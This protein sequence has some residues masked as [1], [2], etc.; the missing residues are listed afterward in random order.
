MFADELCEEFVRHALAIWGKY[1]YLFTQDKDIA[2]RDERT[3]PVHRLIREYAI[4]L[5]KDRIG[6]W[7]THPL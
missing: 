2:Y 7:K 1:L 5:E 3:W 4:C 6:G